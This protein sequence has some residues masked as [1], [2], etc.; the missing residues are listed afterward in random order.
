MLGELAV[1]FAVYFVLLAMLEGLR[2]LTVRLVRGA[3]P[4]AKA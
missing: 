2:R 3:Q 1:S 4:P